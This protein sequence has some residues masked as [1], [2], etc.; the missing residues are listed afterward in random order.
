MR[1]RLMAKNKVQFQKG[2]S[3]HRF[4]AMYGSE[5]Q[6]QKQ[7]FN[8]RW[9]SGYCYPNCGHDKY[10]LLKSRRLYQCNQC[11]FQASLTSGTIF[12]YSK[13]P[14]TTWF[15]AIYFSSSWGGHLAD[16]MYNGGVLG[17]GGRHV[18]TNLVLSSSPFFVVSAHPG[19]L[20]SMW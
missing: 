9:S 14:L 7:L 17:G 13:L 16:I 5:T 1:A 19:G 3:I 6:C 18:L 11:H 20:W 4:M 15:M 2:I 12:A 8:M 10:C